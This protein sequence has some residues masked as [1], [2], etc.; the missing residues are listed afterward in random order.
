MQEEH[1][2]ER[3]ADERDSERSIEVEGGN[4]FYW[5]LPIQ[6]RVGGAMGAD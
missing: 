2:W 3:D 4:V 6:E 5:Q 1:E